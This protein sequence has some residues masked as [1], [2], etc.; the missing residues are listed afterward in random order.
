M[1]RER[2]RLI[3]KGSKVLLIHLGTITNIFVF[4]DAR[5]R[6]LPSLF[7]PYLVRETTTVGVSPFIRA[8]FSIA[9]PLE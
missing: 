4:G 6:R 3:E 8:L 2:E 9:Q 7:T 1:Y 5:L